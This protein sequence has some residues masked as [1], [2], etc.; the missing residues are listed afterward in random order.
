MAFTNVMM[1]AAPENALKLRS[2]AARLRGHA[3][4]THVELY[5]RKFESVASELEEAAMD[6]ESRKRPS[7]R[8]VS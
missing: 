1:H 5:R 3:A 8:Q 4:A 6:A 2:L 7:L